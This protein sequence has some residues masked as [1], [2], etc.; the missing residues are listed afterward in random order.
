MMPTYY[1]EIEYWKKYLSF[2]PKRYQ[3]LYE[4][5]DESYWNWKQE[6]IHLDYRVDKSNDVT[7][8]LIHGAGGNGR[9]LSMFGSYL[10]SNGV[11][12][13]APDNLGYGLTKLSNR[14]FEYG[15]WVDMIS[16]FT[17]YINPFVIH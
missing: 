1:K 15:D 6:K 16:D 17:R 3:D 13:Y 14:K 4:I 12:Y 11:N 7:V 10:S 2:L 5:P 8:I 9:I